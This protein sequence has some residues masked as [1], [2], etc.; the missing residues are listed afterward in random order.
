MSHLTATERFQIETL[1]NAGKKPA[2]IAKQLK[3]NKSTISREIARNS[4]DGIYCHDI[5]QKRTAQRRYD[6]KENILTADN[7]TYVRSLLQQ[8]WSP[9]QMSGWLRRHPEVGF[10]VSDQWIY[11]YIHADRA[12]G[13]TLY[14][15]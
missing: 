15:H 1:L 9:E 6:A 4:Q 7:W 11:E 13:G 2:S 5:A 10:Y 8:K 3:R 14:T 12:Q